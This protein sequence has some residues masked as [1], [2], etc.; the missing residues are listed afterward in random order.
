MD[1]VC[2]RGLGRAVGRQQ[3]GGDRCRAHDEPRSHRKE[4]R[5]VGTAGRPH[6]RLS[7]GTAA[8]PS[9]ATTPRPDRVD[10]AARLRGAQVS[11]PH[12]GGRED[13]ARETP[14][15]APSWSASSGRCAKGVGYG[16]LRAPVGHPAGWPAATP[17]ATGATGR[18]V[19]GAAVLDGWS[20]SWALCCK[21]TAQIPGGL[22]ARPRP[23]NTWENLPLLYVEGWR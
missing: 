7:V 15:S 4:A 9:S 21:P 3:C 22:P 16:S 11:H 23:V 5:G 17:L 18:R 20:Y 19:G 12:P 2:R 6:R 13:E 1:A 10:H 8:S 14:A